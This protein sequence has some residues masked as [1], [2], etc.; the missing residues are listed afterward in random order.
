MDIPG[1]AGYESKL[2]A[3]LVAAGSA[4]QQDLIKQ[5]E[6]DP[7][8]TIPDGFW[9]DVEKQRRAALAAFILIV[10]FDS[11]T[12]HGLDKDRA[13]SK[14]L[15]WVANRAA[16]VARTATNNSK[17]QVAQH[18]SRWRA[19]QQSFSSKAKP[20]QTGQTGG[21]FLGNRYEVPKSDRAELGE[22]VFGPKK[23][24][25]IASTEV[26][27]A[28]TDASE[29]AVKLLNVASEKDVWWTEEDQRV[30]PICGPIHNKKRSE[31]E[32]EFPVGPPAHPNC[33]CWI[34]Y[35]KVEISV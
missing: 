18:Q 20:G 8:T 19:E 26:T 1:R 32:G 34:A 24:G 4:H 23:A 33:R 16:T 30:C 17:Q 11:A 7:F 10:F 31:W 5:L 9:Q 27:N 3:G 2:T 13:K 25:T 15:T 6:R 35:S 14:G 12:R 21:Q 29:M 22:K 28:I